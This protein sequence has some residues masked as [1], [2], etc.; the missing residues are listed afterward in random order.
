MIGKLR[1]RA[2]RL[3]GPTRNDTASTPNRLGDVLHLDNNFLRD[4]GLS[5]LPSVDSDLV[6]RLAYE[7]L[8]QRVGE[9]LAE[10]M[11]DEQLDEFEGFIDR[12]DEPEALA[13]LERHFPQYRNTVRSQLE[14]LKEEIRASAPAMIEE[15]RR[16]PIGGADD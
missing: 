8:E 14:A 15:A 1:L 6:L 2:R 11:S 16:R 5:S 4:V 13:W 7:I 12:D 3:V 10:Q 9:E